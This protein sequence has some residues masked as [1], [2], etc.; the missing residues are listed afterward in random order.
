MAGEIKKIKIKIN[1]NECDDIAK[2][3]LHCIP[4]IRCLKLVFTK[5]EEKD[6]IN[7]R[8]AQRLHKVYTIII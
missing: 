7:A 3:F 1:V 2:S 8:N 6:I 5:T 4:T